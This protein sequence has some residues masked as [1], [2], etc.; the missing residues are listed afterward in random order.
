MFSFNIFLYNLILIK[1]YLP[2]I[3]LIIYSP[4]LYQILFGEKL[5]DKCQKESIFQLHNYFKML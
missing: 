3:R 5:I 4:K 2:S 1:L